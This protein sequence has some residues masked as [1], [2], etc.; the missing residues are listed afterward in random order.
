M[1]V[2]SASSMVWIGTEEPPGITALNRRPAGG[3]PHRS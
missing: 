2:A 1:S 3:P